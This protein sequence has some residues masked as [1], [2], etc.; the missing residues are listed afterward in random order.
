MNVCVERM[1]FF[2]G[3]DLADRGFTVCSF[4]GLN[5]AELGV[6]V[7]SFIL[8]DL[9]EQGVNVCSFLMLLFQEYFGVNEFSFS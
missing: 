6:I 5:L 8:P 3:L 7:C 1:F 9:L 4:T 2:T